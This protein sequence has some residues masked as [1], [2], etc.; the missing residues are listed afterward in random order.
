MLKREKT[1]C[2]AP[3]MSRINYPLLMGSLM[4]TQR[5]AD[6]GLCVL[7]CSKMAAK[8]N[9][10]TVF[11]FYT[12]K[13]FNFYSNAATSGIILF[14]SS[15]E[16][17]LTKRFPTCLTRPPLKKARKVVRQGF[18]YSLFHLS[19]DLFHSSL[20]GEVGQRVV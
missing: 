3:Q 14:I 9:V 17:I 8:L 1:T 20:V 15:L 12:L 6:I 19:S 11:L 5:A 18:F 10:F 4:G 16:A 13:K 2:R 7:L